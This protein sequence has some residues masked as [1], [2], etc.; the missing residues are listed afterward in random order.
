MPTS[1]AV[2]Q[3]L[4]SLLPEQG[5]RPP[6]RL[7]QLAES[8]LAQSRQRA[9]HLKPEEEIGRAYACSEIACTRLRAQLRLP[10]VKTGGAPCKP[11]VYKKLVKF[12]DGVLGEDHAIVNST[13]QTASRKRTVDGSV[14]TASVGASGFGT[15]TKARFV[16]R[17]QARNADPNTEEAE[18]PKFVTPSI[19][20]LCKAFSTPLLAPHVYTGSC[21]VLKL[22][23][24]WP[25]PLDEEDE[26]ANETETETNF[27]TNV[28]GL[29][30]ALY[31][32]VL[33]RMQKAKMTTAVYNATSGKALQVLQH[34]AEIR[35]VE[36]WIKTINEEGYCK[37]HEWWASVPEA[38]FDFVLDDVEDAVDENA[39]EDDELI[40]S[41]RRCARAH[42]F[43]GHDLDTADDPEGVLLPGLGT[44]MQDT[45]DWTSTERRLEFSLWKIDMM[46]RLD[47]MDLASVKAKPASV[48]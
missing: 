39:L 1:S 9:S 43:Q 6:P 10:A 35:N 27:R 48:R 17:V 45:V 18:A 33:T 5:S 42:G 26:L 3:S 41:G 15:P 2:T 16:G 46:K 32:L 8:L 12:L 21:V 44:M 25:R 40:V 30:V 7:V 4:C 13:P 37:S 19:R 20:K 14:K 11:A 47:E 24:M 28:I 34:P 29:V 36:K 22:A 31:L 23:G 38:V